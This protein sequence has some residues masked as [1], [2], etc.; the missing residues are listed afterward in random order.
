[1]EAARAKKSGAVAYIAKPF[2]I[3]QLRDLILSMMQGSG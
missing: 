3:S 1:V 2:K